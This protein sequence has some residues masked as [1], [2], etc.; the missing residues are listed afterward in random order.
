MDEAFFKAR[1]EAK[2]QGLRARRLEQRIEELKSSLTQ[3]RQ[4]ARRTQRRVGK[5]RGRVGQLRKE[6]GDLMAQMQGIQAS[7]SWKLVDGLNRI[8]VKI[9]GRK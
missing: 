8:R 4:R 9:L 2:A 3:E 7:K 1:A 5:L 6:N